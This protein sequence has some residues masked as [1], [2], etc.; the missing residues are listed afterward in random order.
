MKLVQFIKWLLF[1]V[2][3][4]VLTI[5]ENDYIVVHCSD[6]KRAIQLGRE[7]VAIKGKWQG[8][9]VAGD[10]INVDTV[11]TLPEEVRSKLLSALLQAG[12]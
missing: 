7:L 10:D 9:I 6:I 2:R 12:E 3:L 5:T 11:R 1:R 4:N 8:V